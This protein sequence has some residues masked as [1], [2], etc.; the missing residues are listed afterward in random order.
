MNADTKIVGDDINAML[1][2]HPRGLRI[3]GIV[4]LVLGTLA[5]LLPLAAALA[6]DLL[7]GWLLLVGGVALGLQAFRTAHGT[8]FWWQFGM[9]VLNALTGLLLLINPMQGVLTLT[10]VLSVF[11]LLEGGFKVMLALSM[12]AGNGWGWLL[13]SGLVAVLLGVLILTGLPGSATWAL[14]LMVGINLL[15]TGLALL[16]MAKVLHHSGGV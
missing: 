1:R 11:F 15:F 4:L 13:F 2:Q 7:L 12:R 14:G 6:V 8:R 5:I 10:V 3:T 16:S 9:A